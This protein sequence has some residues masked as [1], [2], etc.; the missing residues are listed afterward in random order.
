MAKD[1]GKRKRRGSAEIEGEL[2]AARRE[3]DS[4]ARAL[5]SDDSNAARDRF[6]RACV[7]VAQLDAQLA[8]SVELEA[9]ERRAA[10]ER[11]LEPLRAEFERCM[12]VNS[13]AYIN[14]RFEAA[15][16]PLIDQALECLQQ[17]HMEAVKLHREQG[18]ARARAETIA[19]E[20][21]RRFE[22]RAPV[23]GS[24]A[25]EVYE[26]G[27]RLVRARLRADRSIPADLSMWIATDR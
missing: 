10:E 2:A 9:A 1:D 27:R 24:T 21:G 12:G 3:K 26:L 5:L 7:R 22:F 19:G 20:V 15:I 17:A 23:L 11:R 14:R 4:T 25:T 6:D 13:T 8:A 18:A 16:A